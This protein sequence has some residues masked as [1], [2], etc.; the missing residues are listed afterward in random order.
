MIRKISHVSLPVLDQD[1]A[2]EFYV[3]KLGFEVRNDIV[4][5][6]EFEG[7]GQGFRWLTVGPPDQPDVE[8]ILADVRMGHSPQTSEEVRALVAKGALGTGVFAT[9]DCH[10]TFRE[11]SERGVVFVQEPV[12]RPYG[13][14]A[15]FRD[16]SGN[17]FSLTQ[18]RWRNPVDRG[19][20]R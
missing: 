12:E 7:G 17:S 5:D 16:D 19:A 1:S 2:K 8:I 15:V 18:A 4:M 20:L 9:D 10:K 13:I 11:L 6:E 3:D 14:E